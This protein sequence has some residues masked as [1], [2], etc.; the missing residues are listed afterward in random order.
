MGQGFS[1]ERC[2]PW[3]SCLV[4]FIGFTEEEHNIYWQQSL[5]HPFQVQMNLFVK[6]LNK[7]TFIDEEAM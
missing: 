3:T 1:G 6:I 7:R 5:F 4:V 2:G